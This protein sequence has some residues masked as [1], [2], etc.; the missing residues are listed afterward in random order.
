MRT[1][2]GTAGA[3]DDVRAAIHRLGPSFER[4]YITHTTLSHWADI[5][6]EMVARRVRAV[7]VKDKKLF[8]Y[9]PDAVW[10]NEMRMSAPEIVQRVNNYA[11]GRMVTE[12]AFARTM[13]PIMETADDAAA[14]TPAAYRRALAQTGLTDAEIAHGAALASAASDS[15]L[16]THIERAYLTMRKARNLKEARGLTPCPVCGRFVSGACMDCRRSEER[17]LRREVRAILRREPWAKLADITRRIPSA[18]ALMVGSERADLIRSIAG[19]T[20]YTAQDSENA[21]LLTMLHRGLPPEQVTPKKIQSTFWELRNE[22]IT[23]REFWEEMK[24][25]RAKKS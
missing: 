21:R 1:T 11:G 17:G 19:R 24:Q 3:G 16:R 8:L 23:T 25:R 2:L 18:D 12:I 6:G 4:D 7:A 20:E 15:D 10:K 13:R 14:E 9:A 5:M 22:L